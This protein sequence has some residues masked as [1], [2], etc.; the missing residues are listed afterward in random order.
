MCFFLNLNIHIYFKKLKR[1]QIEP[2]HNTIIAFE[3]IK[4]FNES[5]AWTCKL[6]RAAMQRVIKVDV[7]ISLLHIPLLW[8]C[9]CFFL[10]WYAYRSWSFVDEIDDGDDESERDDTDWIRFV[11]MKC[12]PVLAYHLTVDFVLLLFLVLRWRCELWSRFVLLDS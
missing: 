10:L 6:Q 3:K 11:Q 1:K 2:Q 9:C 12:K 7:F 5:H 8:C 4:Y